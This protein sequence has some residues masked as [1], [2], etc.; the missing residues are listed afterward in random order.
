MR[1]V[2]KASS[3]GSPEL[4]DS[5][6][7]EPLFNR[8]TAWFRMTMISI[9]VPCNAI[10]GHGSQSRG[11]STNLAQVPRFRALTLR[12]AHSVWHSVWLSV[13]IPCLVKPSSSSKL[14]S[15][16]AN[17]SGIRQKVQKRFII[18]LVNAYIE[19][20]GDVLV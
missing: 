13:S 17:T 9:H 6:G 5:L 1:V 15:S 16:L 7:G 2:E 11:V 14:S 18:D 8:E 12:H 10:L 19:G 3:F 20:Y 4:R